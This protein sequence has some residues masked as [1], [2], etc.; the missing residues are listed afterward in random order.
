MASQFI[1]LKILYI[2][3]EKWQRKKV[4]YFQQVEHKLLQHTINID[5][6]YRHTEPTKKYGR[7]GCLLSQ[8]N[9]DD[10]DDD[11]DGDDD[12]EDVDGDDAM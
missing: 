6:L 4:K 2:I 7:C 10:D 1:K 11:G 9:E 12:D 3:Q 8:S 5:L